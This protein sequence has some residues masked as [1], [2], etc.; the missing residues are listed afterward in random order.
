MFTQQT[1]NLRS[2]SA[3]RSS[4]ASRS[5]ITSE[6]TA[7][8]GA[9][10]SW[11][12][13]SRSSRSSAGGRYDDWEA[14]D[15]DDSFLASEGAPAAQQ[16][17]GTIPKLSGVAAAQKEEPASAPGAGSGSAGT[18]RTEEDLPD[19]GKVIRYKNGTEKRVDKAGNSVVNFLNGDTK[20]VNVVTGSVVYFYAEAK[21][22]HT[23]YGDG[24]EVYEFPNGQVEMQFP[25]GIK[26][27]VF[28]DNTRK[29]IH[30]DGLQVRFC[31]ECWM[32]PL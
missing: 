3:A 8:G 9:R 26:E 15:R 29:V 22:T 13:S 6:H 20:T 4:S 12:R 10:D 16:L 18:G 30:P 25:D 2:S 24:L 27:I 11:A 28:P 21:T 19:G 1:S 31:C 14:S 5:A 7:P 23:T 32:Y 17:N